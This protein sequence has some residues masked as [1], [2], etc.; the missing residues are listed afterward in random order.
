MSAKWLITDGYGLSPGGPQYI[1]TMGLIPDGVEPPAVDN[2]VSSNW[3]CMGI[4]M[5]L[6]I[7][8]LLWGRNA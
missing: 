3:L 7:F 4:R 5:G 6:F 8:A 2:T 1:V